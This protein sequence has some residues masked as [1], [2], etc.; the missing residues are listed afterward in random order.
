MEFELSTIDIQLTPA[1][2]TF[3][4]A[5]AILESAEKL[6]QQLATVSVNEENIKESKRLVA[7][8]RKR[9]NEIDQVR[10]DIKRD[11][12]KPYIEFESVV[13]EIL[14]TV[15]EGENMVR[16][17]VRELEERERE[18]KGDYLYEVVNKRLRHY[19][20]IVKYEVSPDEFI[21]PQYLNKTFSLDKAELG[22]TMKLESV[23]DDL[24]VLHDLEDSSELI[25]DYLTHFSVSKSLSNVASRKKQLEEI[26]RRKQE[27]HK[28]ASHKEAT[29]K[30]TA[31]EGS[32][33]TEQSE[34]EYVI[35]VFSSDDY[36]KLLEY[37][38]SEDIKFSKV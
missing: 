1:Q 21:L 9:A 20:L 33:S 27:L 4:S 11:I 22:I 32:K 26:E 36:I 31:Q 3:S 19:P 35:K 7:S 10:K 16:S 2:I 23:E 13:K 14:N 28:E 12:L 6:N 8:V 17:Q 25:I 34:R 38:T 24:A 30:Q 15:E 18:E 5:G 37:M 29:Q